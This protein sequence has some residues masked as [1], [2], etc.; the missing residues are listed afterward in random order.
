M[1]Q[2]AARSDR[3]R[4]LS[5]PKCFP[6]RPMPTT[7]TRE[8]PAFPT[9]RFLY[10]DLDT[11]KTFLIDSPILEITTIFSL[12]IVVCRGTRYFAHHAWGRK[13]AFTFRNCPSSNSPKKSGIRIQQC[14]QLIASGR[15]VDIVFDHPTPCAGNELAIQKPRYLRRSLSMASPD[16]HKS[17]LPC[18][19]ILCETNASRRR[20]AVSAHPPVL[21]PCTIV[22]IF[23]VRA[24]GIPMILPS[25][26]KAMR[27]NSSPIIVSS[28]TTPSCSNDFCTLSNASSMV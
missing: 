10:I 1:P 12:L 27:E 2:V 6:H 11:G 26:T 25:S 18:N 4:P 16:L 14:H 17:L 9:L 7:A 22:G 21:S 23:K 28:S 5:R 19:P 13:A 3:A 24:T 15:P 8:L 20:H